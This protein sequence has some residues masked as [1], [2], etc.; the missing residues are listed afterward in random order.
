M[1]TKIEFRCSEEEK[2]SIIENAKKAGLD[3]SKFCRQLCIDGIKVKR[4]RLDTKSLE[5]EINKLS[6]EIKKVGVNVNQMA[7][8]LNA[9]LGISIGNF[10]EF[11]ESF[12][13][14]QDKMDEIQEKIEEV[15][16][17]WQ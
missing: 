5:S 17:T 10:D 7:H 8:I 6:W 16:S 1:K 15:Y 3:V 2:E 14:I 13:M 9:N 4:N 11:K 12:K